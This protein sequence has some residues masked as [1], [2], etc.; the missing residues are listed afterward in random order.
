MNY[1]D[2]ADADLEQVYL[3]RQADA[4][5][6]ALVSKVLQYL[7]QQE[8]KAKKSFEDS[9]EFY[10]VGYHRAIQDVRSMIQEIL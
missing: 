7:S 4:R 3:E 9:G 10:W 6:L 5:E 2:Y 1:N 8:H